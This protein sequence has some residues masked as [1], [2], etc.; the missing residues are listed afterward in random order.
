MTHGISAM[1]RDNSEAAVGLFALALEDYDPMK[2]RVLDVSR[3]Q[4][5]PD[6]S[7]GFSEYM[8]FE[9]AKSRGIEAVVIRC[10]VGNYYVDPC[11]E[12]YWDLAGAAGLLRSAYHVVAPA[13]SVAYGNKIISAESQIA[14][15]MAHFGY[16]QPD[17]ELVQDCELTRNQSPEI[18]TNLI[19]K[20]IDL[21]E[22]YNHN[23]MIYTRGNWWQWNVRRRSYWQ[24]YP[25]W[26][27]RYNSY[28]DHPWND[29]ENT[30]P[31]DWTEW[32]LWQWSADGNNMG[33]FYGSAGEEDIDLNRVRD[34]NFFETQPP[35]NGGN[36]NVTKLD[37]FIKK[38]QDNNIAMTARIEYS[39]GDD[40]GDDN[41]D[42]GDPPVEPPPGN[43]DEPEYPANAETRVIAEYEFEHDE[44]HKIKKPFVYQFVSW[45]K[46]PDEA[47]PF[48]VMNIAKIGSP[49]WQLEI[50]QKVL[51][52]HDKYRVS[53]DEM[54][55][56]NLVRE[57]YDHGKGEDVH[58][59]LDN[60]NLKK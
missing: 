57:W 47:P 34:P 38:M 37:D 43:G 4:S 15:F 29:D 22:G 27:A 50:G 51:V 46:T 55:K 36:G 16:R 39:T 30:D 8:D 58:Y 60:G 19:K 13:T 44:E 5:M 40:W 41:G 12:T 7:G 32:D 3:Y 2:T 56:S 9:K 52:S 21:I 6:G 24:D 54:C 10:T 53:P 26:I 28:I 23:N 35:P 1:I 42:N 18:I 17:F 48:G 49:A 45:K 11:F 59:Y 20:C 33:D 25:L 31:L 14:W